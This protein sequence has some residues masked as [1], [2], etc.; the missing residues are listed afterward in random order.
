MSTDG[1][2]ISIDFPRADWQPWTK[3]GA[4]GRVK[5]A[6]TQGKRFRLLELPPGFDEEHWCTRAHDGYVLE[7]EFT[8]LFSD[9][10]ESCRPGMAFCI[11]EDPHRSRGSVDSSTLV[12]VV[13]TVDTTEAVECVPVTSAGNH[14]APLSREN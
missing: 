12:V 14:A 10:V 2:Q 11:P 9:R 6:Q 13:D 7:G 4:H 5:T 8:I 1:P 3:P